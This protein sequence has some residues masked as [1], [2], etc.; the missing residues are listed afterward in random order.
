MQFLAIS[1]LILSNLLSHKYFDDNQQSDTYFNNPIIDFDA[2]NE[3]KKP[4]A[5]Q[6]EDA[7]IK[8]K[9]AEKQSFEDLLGETS[10]L[11]SSYSKME[12]RLLRLQDTMEELSA[13]FDYIGEKVE[14]RQKNRDKD[15]DRDSDSED[16]ISIPVLCLLIFVMG[17]LSISVYKNIK[18]LK[19]SKKVESRARETE[20]AATQTQF[21]RLDETREREDDISDISDDSSSLASYTGI[22][23]KMT[24]KKRFGFSIRKCFLHCLKRKKK[25]HLTSQ[26]EVSKNNILTLQNELSDE[27][28]ESLH[29]SEES[30]D[31]HSSAIKETVHETSLETMTS[32]EPET[33]PTRGKKKCGRNFFICCKKSKTLDFEDSEADTGKDKLLSLKT[34]EYFCHYKQA[35]I[36]RK[37]KHRKYKNRFW[38]W[39]HHT[40]SA[41]EEESVYETPEENEERNDEV[42]DVVTESSDETSTVSSEMTD[43]ASYETAEIDASR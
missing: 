1:L 27:S 29:V 39:C 17:A 16:T 6:N 7:P 40:A 24:K 22:K 26:Y 30:I 33:V 13:T 34:G 31:E 28:K 3:D 10:Y 18:L 35:K 42:L 21:H 25:K 41:E 23:A 38:Q 32:Y 2:V 43:E 20:N 4:I 8:R 19:K 11:D 14:E 12:A 36:Y 15:Q 9:A 5:E 37:G